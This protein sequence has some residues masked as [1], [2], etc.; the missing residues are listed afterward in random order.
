[1]RRHASAAM[2]HR[3]MDLRSTLSQ[4]LPPQRGGPAACSQQGGERAERAGPPRP[5]QAGR[6][7]GPGAAAQPSPAQRPA[8]GLHPLVC[9]VVRAHAV[10]ARQLGGIV[11]PGLSDVMVHLASRGS[12]GG[13]GVDAARTGG[14]AGGLAP[15][16]AGAF[17]PPWFPHGS[18]GVGVA[19]ARRGRTCRRSATMRCDWYP[20]TRSCAVLT[21]GRKGRRA[22]GRRD[23]KLVPSNNVR[24]R[25]RGG[26]RP[27]Q[28]QHC[29]AAG[30]LA[31][32][33]G[34][35]PRAGRGSRART[36]VAA[37]PVAGVVR[38]RRLHRQPR[39][40]D[41]LHQALLALLRPVAGGV[42]VQR[43]GLMRL[44]PACGP[45]G[46]GG[47]AGAGQGQ[48]GERG[49]P[50]GRAT[51]GVQ[52]LPHA[53][54]G[55]DT[56]QRPLSQP[57][58]H[59]SRTGPQ[60]APPTQPVRS[61]Q[62]SACIPAGLTGPQDAPVGHQAGGCLVPRQQRGQA[63][64]RGV[65]QHQELVAVDEG[66]AGT[67]RGR[68]DWSASRQ[69]TGLLH[70]NAAAACTL[71]SP[72]R[73]PTDRPGPGQPRAPSQACLCPWSRR[74]APY[75]IHCTRRGFL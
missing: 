34:C 73:A 56:P 75:T 11:V 19:A 15:L 44:V 17:A 61:R 33:A 24:R 10:A 37:A 39:L 58:S 21:A 71:Q 55:G 18:G 8:G 51:A 7:E 1:M 36:R 13:D 66:C 68:C 32:G 47:G 72:Q 48:V 38:R 35:T 12:T 4:Y 26:R 16:R 2:L 70:C 74:Q 45:L 5:Q 30:R 67:D 57:A 6:G 23:V 50:G 63:G 31:G 40:H 65:E 29:T 60:N 20:S 64:G 46:Q 52:R 27:M 42:A 3:A 28:L 53:A 54:R 69:R 62:S 14:G 9:S 43:G 59:T 41:A 49:G 22:R 25:G